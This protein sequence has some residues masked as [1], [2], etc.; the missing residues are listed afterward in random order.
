[1]MIEWIREP[2]FLGEIN[3]DPQISEALLE[4]IRQEFERITGETVPAIPQ[5]AAC[6]TIKIFLTDP[7][8]IEWTNID[9]DAL[10]TAIIGCPGVRWPFIEGPPPKG[11]PHT[12]VVQDR[13]FP[14][15][16]AERFGMAQNWQ[17]L[18]TINKHKGEPFQTLKV[19]E[20]LWLPANWPGQ[21]VVA[22]L[23]EQPS[24]KPGGGPVARG[25]RSPGVAPLPIADAAPEAG[26]EAAIEKVPAPKKSRAGFYVV[27]GLVGVGIAA[28]L[29]KA[30]QVVETGEA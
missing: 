18:V 14:K 11:A 3:L 13:D 23:L 7:S 2:D 6:E 8:T 29:Y 26:A 21:P 30:S 25:L 4:Q 17:D 22:E 16:I 10:F 19:G 12:Y 15:R 27:I 1:M 20:G 5:S 9:P 24:E 28:A